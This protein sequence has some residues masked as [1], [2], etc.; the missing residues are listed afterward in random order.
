MMMPAGYWVCDVCGTTEGYKRGKSRKILL[1]DVPTFE[2]LTKLFGV[3]KLECAVG[4]H[5][6]LLLQISAR[7]PHLVYDGAV[8]FYKIKDFDEFIYVCR[9]LDVS[10]GNDKLCLCKTYEEAREKFGDI[11]IIMYE[12]NPRPI[13][14]ELLPFCVEEDSQVLVEKEGIL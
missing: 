8:F 3:V 10:L 11:S 4:N 14:D 9:V 2:L 7:Y 1:K 6:D 13:P 5:A 12:E